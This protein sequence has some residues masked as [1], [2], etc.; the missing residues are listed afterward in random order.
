MKSLTMSNQT[1]VSSYYSVLDLMRKPWPFGSNRTTKPLSVIFRPVV[2]RTPLTTAGWHPGRCVITLGYR[3][4]LSIEGYPWFPAVE[5]FLQAFGG[6]QV[7]FA[8]AGG[9]DT[10]HFHAR[11]AAGDVDSSWVRQ[12]FIRLYDAE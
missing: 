10:F 5:K 11:K 1:K 9:N 3:L 7:S 8:R 6:L 4:S 12:Y 2:T